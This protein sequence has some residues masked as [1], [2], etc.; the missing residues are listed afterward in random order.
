MSI[1]DINYE[2]Y[3]Y[4]M[5]LENENFVKYI[6]EEA[7]K[8]WLLKRKNRSF[9]KKFKFIKKSV[10]SCAKSRFKGRFIKNCHFNLIPITLLQK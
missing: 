9:K 5:K 10:V 2:T 6:I 8:K 3:L 4:T 7:K 1:Y